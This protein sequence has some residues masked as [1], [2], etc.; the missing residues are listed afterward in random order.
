MSKFRLQHWSKFI[1]PLHTSCFIFKQEESTSNHCQDTKINLIYIKRCYFKTIQGSTREWK[2][3]Q[4]LFT[5]FTHLK[6]NYCATNTE[7]SRGLGDVLMNMHDGCSQG[8][9]HLTYSFIQ[10]T[11]T[12]FLF[13]FYWN[14][15]DLQCCVSF[16]CTAKWFKNIFIIYYI[17]NVYMCVCVCPVT[18]VVSDSLKP[19]GL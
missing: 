13:N 9:S 5:L 1:L 6:D 3:R 11:F 7:L 14:I 8:T 19:H 17:Y 2:K 15:V 10:V 18:S 12:K 4:T 16:R